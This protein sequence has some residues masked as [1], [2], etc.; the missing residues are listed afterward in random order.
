MHRTVLALLASSA[1]LIAGAAG[2]ARA[3]PA[4][5]DLVGPNL[6]V[7]VTRQGVTLPIGAVPQMAVGDKLTIEVVLPA[8]E[9]AHYLLV[10]AFL[11]D[12]TNPPPLNWFSKSEIWKHGK[13][14]AHAIELTIPA[15]AQHLVLFL[16]PSTGGD[17]NTL[18]NAV[19][20]R[21]GAFVRASQDLEQASL[22]RSRYNTYLAAIERVSG[23]DPAKLASIA[24]IVADSLLIKINKDCLQRQPELQAACLLDSKQAA[25]L[26]ADSSA[27]SNAMA[28]AAT[29]LALSLASTP[30]GGLGYY[31]PYI[32]TIRDIVGIFGAMHTAKYQYI[33][34]LSVARGD[35]V[36][37][38]LNTPPSFADPKSVLMAVLPSIK[39][40]HVPTIEVSG[41]PEACL[42]A[43]N[44]LL[45]VPSTPLIYATD[46][47]HDLM[48][49]VHL[50]DNAV[51]DLPLT[52]D[53][54][55]GGLVIGSAAAPIP[56]HLSGP[57]TGTIHGMWGFEPFSG[58]E[59]SL[60]T[61]GDWHWKTGDSGKAEGVVRLTGA[62]AAC[63]LGVTA[64]SGKDP[65][66]DGAKP[67]AWKAASPQEIAVT[68]P[69][70]GEKSEPVTLSIA[71]PPGTAPA[72]MVIAP[73][74]GTP[75]PVVSIV[76]HSSEL[77]VGD[78]TPAGAIALGNPDLIPADQRLNFTLKAEGNEHFSGHEV[79]EVATT[80]GEATAH[81]TLGNGMT[82]VDQRAIVGTVTP[83]QALGSSA[84][85]P[86]RARLMRNGVAGA[87]LDLGTLVRL[88]RLKQVACAPDHAAP[89]TL[90]G[91]GLF[92]LASVSATPDFDGAASVAE[93]YPGFTLP[94]PHPVSGTL[95]VRLHDAPEIVNRV[96][97]SD[98]AGH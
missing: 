68:I 21:P 24:P 67:V 35:M 40:A 56:A 76:A 70:M 8:D 47:A 72:T 84:F 69:A 16:A 4:P 12:P 36:S 97:F 37:L 79:I 90:S 80:G 73:P 57:V 2:V 98:I 91:E 83:G 20:A 93:G 66:P 19:A 28:G 52:A 86:L 29:D 75:P 44:P 96:H 30:Q 89:C 64:T 46:Y 25:V 53:V 58:P 61:P 65:G 94:V 82:L 6:H 87:W 7:M 77:P 88:P 81:L 18:H 85:G 59:V 41:A 17:F 48:V 63:V 10:S 78:K 33:P 54:T 13:H 55:R 26:S 71:G 45:R 15:G 1:L 43:E 39:P 3:D 27:G 49:R 62:P 5:F 42:G 32:S 60:Q 31:S 95:F 14:P 22:D 9:T 38:V 51:A 11:R 34:A 74:A 92:L 50:P 23:H